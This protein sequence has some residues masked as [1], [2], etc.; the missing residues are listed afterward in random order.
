[1]NNQQIER[2]R[3]KINSFYQ[4]SNS[5]F[6]M[7]ASI[8]SLQQ[9]NKNNVFV[10][11]GSV[12]RYFS[13]LDSGYMISYISNIEGKIYNKNIFSPDD[14]VGFYNIKHPTVSF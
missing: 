5:S 7:I 1:M 14:W 6:D 3:S 9:I 13:Y 2:L 10:E 12:S 4:I 11:Q 8:T